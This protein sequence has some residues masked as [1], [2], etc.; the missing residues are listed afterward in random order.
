[1]K[2]AILCT[3]IATLLGGCSTFDAATTS[4]TASL[5]APERPYV[6]IGAGDAVGDR[7]FSPTAIAERRQEKERLDDTARAD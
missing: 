1:M 2:N 4:P 5:T 6:S 3:A 7:L